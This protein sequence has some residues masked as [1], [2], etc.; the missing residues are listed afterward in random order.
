[1]PLRK[2]ASSRSS[3]VSIVKLTPRLVSTRSGYELRVLDH[4]LYGSYYQLS[5][6]SKGLI[7]Q[8]NSRRN[9]PESVCAW[10]YEHQTVHVLNWDLLQR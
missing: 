5:S 7:L 9:Y 3:A 2:Y 8:V 1:M 6:P 4:P 10:E